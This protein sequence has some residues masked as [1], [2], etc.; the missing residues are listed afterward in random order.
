MKDRT[1]LMELM[2]TFVTCTAFIC[3]LEGILGMLF[4][5][6]A[7]F[8]Y[9]AFFSPPIFGFL[10]SLL[11][12]VT[13]SQK[14]LSAKQMLLRKAF[15][16]FLI[17][18]LIFGLNYINGTVFG[19]TLCWALALGIA[20]VYAAVCGVLWLNDCRS[21]AQFNRKLAQFQQNQE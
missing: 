3:L 6:E 16:L 11:G 1:F 4:L 7:S 8:G 13:H 10:S 9:E 19:S 5:P 12:I 18:L 14:V 17:E 20:L 15:H 2:M 21:A